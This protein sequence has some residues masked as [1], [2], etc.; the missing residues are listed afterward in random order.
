MPVTTTVQSLF[1]KYLIA[2]F[3]GWRSLYS[4]FESAERRILSNPSASAK[5]LS[6]GIC[7]MHTADSLC[8][9]P[10]SG[11]GIEILLGTYVLISAS[12]SKFWKCKM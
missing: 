3:W 12:S 6:A 4:L 9:E 1:K 8:S 11:C 7:V 2:L 5:W 10:S